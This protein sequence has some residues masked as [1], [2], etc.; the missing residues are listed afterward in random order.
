MVQI[1]EGLSYLN[2]QKNPIIHYDLKPGNI[3]FHNGGF[4][5][6]FVSVFV[7]LVVLLF[8]CFLFFVFVFKSPK[9]SNYSL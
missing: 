6:V 1:L 4:V 8:C 9:K 3:L 5:S 7:F 2:H